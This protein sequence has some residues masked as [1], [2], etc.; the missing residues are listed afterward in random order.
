MTLYSRVFPPIWNL[1]HDSSREKSISF[2]FRGAKNSLAVSR[3]H[4][5]RARKKSPRFTFTTS[6]ISTIFRCVWFVFDSFASLFILVNILYYV[7]ILYYQARVFKLFTNILI[8]SKTSIFPQHAVLWNRLYNTPP[9][10][11]PQDFDFI[12]ALPDAYNEVTLNRWMQ[13][14]P[15][16]R[17]FVAP[18][19]TDLINHE[20]AA[21]LTRA[22]VPSI[23]CRRYA[24]RTNPRESSPAPAR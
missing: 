10:P 17:R 9:P 15:A 3:A 19:C 13:H 5:P 11:L 18:R 7:L 20:S 16:L 14:K 6:Q 4:L 12:A 2:R 22:S 23:T 24:A 8:F 21:R 1:S